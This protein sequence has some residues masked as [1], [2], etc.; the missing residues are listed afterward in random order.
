MSRATLKSGIGEGGAYFD[1]ANGGADNLAAVLGALAASSGESIQY[2]QAT[3]ST[4]V[5]GAILADSPTM[6]ANI[7][8]RAGT[9]GTTGTSTFRVLVNGAPRGTIS[10]DNA[11]ADG[12]SKGVAINAPLEAGDLVELEVTAI[13]TGATDLVAT[14]R[15]KPVTVE[16]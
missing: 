4:G 6:L 7:Y 13:A 10:I 3:P 5:K 8:V 1:N 12:A 15:L 11:E 14:V 16:A 2:S 9:A